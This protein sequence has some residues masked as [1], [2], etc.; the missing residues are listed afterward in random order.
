[1]R[2]PGAK[3][4]GQQK[5][6]K[7]KRR[8]CLHKK[9]GIKSLV[10]N[11]TIWK[12]QGSQAGGKSRTPREIFQDQ[13]KEIEAETA[14]GKIVTLNIRKKSFITPQDDIIQEQGREGLRKT[15]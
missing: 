4:T 9:G 10:L 12:D 1:L 3:K 7:H 14:G 6:K 13:G 15:S 8:T 5:K 11:R 2:K